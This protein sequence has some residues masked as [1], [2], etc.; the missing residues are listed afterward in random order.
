MHVLEDKYGFL[1]VLLHKTQPYIAI[2]QHLTRCLG[3]HLRA[4]GQ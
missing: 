2:T 3:L 4:H 1:H